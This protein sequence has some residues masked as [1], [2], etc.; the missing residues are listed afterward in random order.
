MIVKLYVDISR[1]KINF[2]KIQVLWAGVHIK[3]ELINQDKQM[4][5]ISIKILGVNFGNSIHD[6]SKWGKISESIAKN[7]YLEQSETLFER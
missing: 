7:P 5:L 4:I 2:S 3:I 1:S 6:N